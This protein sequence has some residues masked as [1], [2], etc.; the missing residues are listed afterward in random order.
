MMMAARALITLPGYSCIQCLSILPR[1]TKVCLTQGLDPCDL[2]LCRLTISS[3]EGFG[4]H[5]A[6]SVN[7][8]SWAGVNAAAAGPHG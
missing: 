2:R 7:N 3:A 6:A 8:L 5:G 1:S 4:R